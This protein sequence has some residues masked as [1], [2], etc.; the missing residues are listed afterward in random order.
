MVLEIVK[1]NF[2]DLSFLIPNSNEAGLIIKTMIFVDSIN[3]AQR[4]ATF[5]CITLFLQFQG[6]KEEIIRIFLL[7]LELS[8]QTNFLRDF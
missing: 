7:N 1:P 4:I 2:K 6:R 3:E 8:N 5:L